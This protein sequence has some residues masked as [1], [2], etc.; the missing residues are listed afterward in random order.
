[1]RKSKKAKIIA[2]RSLMLL[3][4]ISFG[5]LITGQFR[6][7]PSRVAD[8]ILPYASLKET[9]EELYVE[10]SQL[11]AEIKSLQKSIQTAQDQADSSVL[12]KSELQI[13]NNKKAVAGLTKLSGSGLIVKLDDSKNVSTSDLSIIHAADLRDIVNLLWSSGAEGITIN[14]QRVVLDT[15]I[16]CIVNTILVNGVRISN[17]FQIQAVGNQAL[18]KQAVEESAILND[19]R[20][21]RDNNG[22]VFTVSKANLVLSSFD[23]TFSAMAGSN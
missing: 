5:I 16:D 20:T 22:V 15:A 2:L 7:I 21:R 12:S 1:M 9:K 10:Q 11:K 23:G 14:D 6:S 13:L 4:S 8:P 17:P 3:I 18:M 19:L